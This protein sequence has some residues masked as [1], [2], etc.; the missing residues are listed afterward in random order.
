MANKKRIL[1]VEDDKRLSHMISHVLR[2]EGYLVTCAFDGQVALEKV[3]SELYDVILLDMM[4]P[5]LNGISVLEQ[6][7]PEYTGVI[8]M[9]TASNDEC[10]EADALALGVHDFITKPIRPHILVAK[11]KALSRLAGQAPTCR[12]S[13]FQI[14]DLTLNTSNRSFYLDDTPVEL[15]EAEFSLMYYLMSHP[16]EIL[17]RAS[18]ISAVRGIEYD[19]HD[20]SIDMRLSSLR[21]KMNDNVPPYKYIKTVRGVGYV[22]RE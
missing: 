10:L 15:T 13:V 4:L 16:G 19:G 6:I 1:L 11:V 22:L 21:K 12:K 18:I 14:Q 9:M 20:R 17:D 3:N 2:H 8:I 5:R 7:L